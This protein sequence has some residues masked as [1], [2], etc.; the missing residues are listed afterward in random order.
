GPL[1]E[2]IDLVVEVSVESKRIERLWEPPVVE[3]FADRARVAQ[4]RTFGVHRGA[5]PNARMAAANLPALARLNR[6]AE[7][8][9]RDASAR[10]ALSARA[11]HRTLRVARSVADLSASDT[12]GEAAVAEA[13]SYRHEGLSS[14]S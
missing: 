7:Q 10:W 11:V 2:R 4:A 5:T 9:L 12:I 6:A 13:L 8:L 3:A 14:V 1:L